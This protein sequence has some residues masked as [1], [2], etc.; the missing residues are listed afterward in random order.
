MRTVRV[1]GTGSVPGAIPACLTKVSLSSR[2]IIWSPRV[3]WL[4]KSRLSR[5]RPFLTAEEHLGGWRDPG[6]KLTESECNGNGKPMHR[7]EALR[8]GKG[9]Q[10]SPTSGHS[11]QPQE[12]RSGCLCS[13]GVTPPPTTW[14]LLQ[15]QSERVTDVP[16]RGNNVRGISGEHMRLGQKSRGLGAEQDLGE[17]RGMP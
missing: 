9:S 6:K 17:W 5:S 4:H 13:L 10:G 8:L 2:V 12:G 3:W 15:R 7:G 1:V 11:S 14:P 16:P